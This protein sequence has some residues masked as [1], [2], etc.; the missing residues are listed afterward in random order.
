MATIRIRE[1]IT[2]D[3][4]ADD[5]IRKAGGSPQPVTLAVSER[6]ISA[7][8]LGTGSARNTLVLPSAYASTTARP[9]STALF[10]ASAAPGVSASMKAAV[11]G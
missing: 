11:S 10:I 9:S 5:R 4:G 2:I 3:M 7:D 6:R 1:W 8:Y